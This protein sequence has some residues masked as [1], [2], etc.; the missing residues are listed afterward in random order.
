MHMT[1]TI[2]TASPKTTTSKKKAVGTW[3]TQSNDYSDWLNNGMINDY[4][5]IGL[6]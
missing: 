6:N 1:T 5:I 4:T 3:I 2:Q